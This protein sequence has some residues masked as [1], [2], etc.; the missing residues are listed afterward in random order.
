MA[1]QVLNLGINAQSLCNRHRKR[2]RKY[3]IY[4]Y[5]LKS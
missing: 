2:L 4:I 3:Y 1:P 5:F